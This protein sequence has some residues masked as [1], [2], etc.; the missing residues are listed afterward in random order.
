MSNRDWP[1]YHDGTP[2]KEN[3]III[4]AYGVKEKVVKVCRDVVYSIREF[5][6]RISGPFTKAND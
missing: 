2:V 4:T 6:H 1:A 3:D 5:E